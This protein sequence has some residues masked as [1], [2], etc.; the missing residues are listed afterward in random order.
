MPEPVRACV[1]DAYGTLLDINSAIAQNSA[2]IVENVDA[3]AALWRQRQLEYTW[4]RSLMK[5]YADFW[6]L[7]EAALEY[8]LSTLGL[9]GRAGL[10]DSLMNSYLKLAA[11]PDVAETLR[12]LR[13]L[14]VATAI[15]SNGTPK[16]LQEALRANN[17]TTYIDACLSVDELK[18]YKP[19]PR[20]YQLVC[21]QLGVSAQQVWFVSSNAW[22]VAGAASFGFNAVWINRQNYAREYHFAPI[23]SELRSLS[24]ISALLHG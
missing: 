14:G 16:M 2:S 1:F 23:H 15:L 17:L 11:Y 19:D 18:I 7:T 21:D 13:S 4:T 6:E 24:E 3:L 5:R 20:V 22:D 12:E 8:A 9:A 10:R